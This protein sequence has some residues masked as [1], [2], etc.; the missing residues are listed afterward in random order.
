MRKLWAYIILMF[1]ALLTMGASITAITANAESNIE[2]QDGREIVFRIADKEDKDASLDEG[3]IE[4]VCEIMEDRM[5]A[6]EIDAYEIVA[7]GEDTIKVTFSSSYAADYENMKYFL[8]F[9]GSFALSTIEDS[10]VAI[11]DELLT[12]DEA[13]LDEVNNFPAIVIPVNVDNAQ[14]KEVI[15]A[16]YDEVDRGVG[17]ISYETETNE[18]GE[19]EEVEVVT[20]YLYLWCDYDVDTDT[21]SRTQ[22]ESEDYDPDIAS[23]VIMKFL[24]DEEQSFYFPDDDY[25]KLVSY[26][27]I[28]QDGDGYTSPAEK[29]Y[30]YSQARYYVNLLNADELDY[31]VTFIYERNVEAWY[32]NIINYGQHA[33][34]NWSSTLVATLV[35]LV[36]VL[37]ALC[38]VYKLLA[39]TAF[40][41]TLGSLFTAV[42][43]TVALSVE[44]NVGA[45]VGL[46]L[47]MLVSVISAVLYFNKFKE[48]CYKGRSLRKA[49]QDAGHRSLWP[50]FDMNLVLIIMG[51]CAFLLGGTYM[52]GFSS[53]CVFGGLASMILNLTCLR[54]GTWL[55]TSNIKW[56]GRYDLFGCDI[57]QIPDSSVG[58]QP[59]YVAPYSDK[60]LT[61]RRKLWG[62]IG[63][64]LCVVSFASLITFGVIY[65][66]NFYNTRVEDQTAQIY[67][68]TTSDTSVVNTAF[69]RQFLTDT[70][71][72]GSEEDEEG[73]SLYLS[74][75]EEISDYM[76]TEY[77]DGVYVNYYYYVVSLN[78]TSIG[79]ETLAYYEGSQLSERTEVM[80]LD[81]LLDYALAQAGV[82]SKATASVKNTVV[83]SS[84][85]PSNYPVILATTVGLLVSSVYLMFRYRPARGLATIA[86]ASMSG[87]VT[88]GL[89]SLFR[90]P[91]SSLATLA[92]PFTVTFAFLIAIFIMNK[93]RETVLDSKKKEI[94]L[95][96]RE[97]IMDKSTSSSFSVILFCLCVL[98]LAVICFFG[99]GPLST[100]LA[101]LAIIVGGLLATLFT[102]TLLGP[103]YQWIYS[104]FYKRREI[105][106][107]KPPKE[108]RNKKKQMAKSSEPEEAIFIG[109]ND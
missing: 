105:R 28:D 68:E 104:L 13:Y 46:V 14:Y 40:V 52:V 30:A 63:S 88:I 26:V 45:I 21:Y 22:E 9:N 102:V 106:R 7:Q 77:E 58:E 54:G 39:P 98:I 67:F 12:D 91:V 5:E 66:G 103:T 32:E 79:E 8:S 50:I 35:A 75:V 55:L 74:Y 94:T 89:F 100:S 44:F 53:V 18:D 27:D 109:I 19:E 62:I 41:L 90:V 83:M 92:L 2:Y 29:E 107:A 64:A 76:N 101:Y 85:Q 108:K 73:T 33:S 81:E 6:A 23:K 97:E 69:V 43:I 10:P 16:A 70:Y 82:D 59:K 31:S 60:S 95:L 78:D 96:D 87:L 1:T 48:E 24:V 34:I 49:T 57:K 36:V 65:D 17:E 61:K 15:Q 20:T 38:F 42:G 51:A 25:D 47:V 80:S 71:V 93:D 56:E 3:A 99:F 11:G 4:E 37:I 84:Y 86:T 72:V